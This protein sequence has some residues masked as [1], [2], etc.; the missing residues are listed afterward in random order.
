MMREKPRRVPTKMLTIRQK[1]GLSQTQ[2]KRRINFDGHYGR[3]SD[4]ERGT[5]HPPVI[6][7]LAYARAG[8]VSLESLVDD[9]MELVI[10]SGVS[11]EQK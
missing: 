7:L 9:E 2:M 10:L 3:I 4:Y 8:N 5:R 6:V 11:K 1:L